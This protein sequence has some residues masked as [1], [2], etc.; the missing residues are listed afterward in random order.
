MFAPTIPGLND[1]EMDAV[2][3]AARA[4]GADTAGYVML[5]LP[6]EVKDLFR[7]W[8]V[9]AVPQRAAR[10]MSLVR[11]MRGG[12]DYDPEWRTRQR[13]EGPIADAVRDRFRL[14][15]KR[16]G[17]NEEPAELDCSQFRVPPASERTKE[18]GQLSLF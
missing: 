15:Y 12:K 3:A 18:T 6:L 14:A 17:F 11:S 7:E 1:H 2:L 5:R 9:E 13:G 16:L 8:L 4:A 10:V